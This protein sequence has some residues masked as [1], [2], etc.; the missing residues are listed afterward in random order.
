MQYV[1]LLY[2]AVLYCTVL[3]ADTALQVLYCTETEIVEGEWEHVGTLAAG[4]S[5]GEPVV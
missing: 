3:Y 4:T 5:S 1:K 2:C